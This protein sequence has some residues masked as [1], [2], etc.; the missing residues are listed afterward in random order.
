MPTFEV[1]R[2]V[3]HVHL[4]ELGTAVL[5][6]LRDVG[7]ASHSEIVQGVARIFGW[8]KTGPIVARRIDDAI[9]RLVADGR[10]SNSGETLTLTN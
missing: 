2:K 7:A 1:S 3:E 5:M 4:Q 8:T 6:M 10:V 9:D